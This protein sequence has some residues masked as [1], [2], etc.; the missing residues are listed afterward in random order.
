ML[1]KLGFEFGV[2][3]PSGAGVGEDLDLLL[4]NLS[5]AVE[6][7]Q[8]LLHLC[9]GFEYFLPWAP[10]EGLAEDFPRLV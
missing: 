10:A 3:N 7:T 2:L 8:F 9:V 5:A 1:L 4:V 6:V